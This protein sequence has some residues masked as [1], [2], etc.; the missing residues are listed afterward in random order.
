MNRDFCLAWGKRSEVE[1][2]LYA[3][4]TIVTETI[5][6]PPETLST[7]FIIDCTETAGTGF[8][9]E[10]QADRLGSGLRGSGPFTRERCWRQLIETI[11]I[12]GEPKCPTCHGLGFQA[13]AH[14]ERIVACPTCGGAE[15]PPRLDPERF[16]VYRLTHLSSTG[17]FRGA[18][19]AIETHEGQDGEQGPWLVRDTET[20]WQSLYG[21]AEE[22][23][24]VE[25]SP[26]EFSKATLKDRARA[27]N[28]AVRNGVL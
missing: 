14:T 10:A 28:E 13:G 9:A 21:C 19:T 15:A 3:G 18:V 20:G 26:G 24:E 12:Q 11:G 17:S 6:T 4:N 8:D 7:Y 25:G 2:Y 16:E 27:T 1:A 5:P 23:A 22:A